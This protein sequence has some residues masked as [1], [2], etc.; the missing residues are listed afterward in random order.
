MRVPAECFYVRFGSFANFLWLQDTLAKWGGDAQ[1]LI[2]LR[3]LDR[4]MSGRMEKQLVLKQTV[5]S[6]M[7]GD[8]VIADV[9]IIGTDMFFREGASYG[10]LF[11][12]RNNLGLSA[13][14]DPAAAGADQGRRREGGESQDRRP[15]RFRTWRRPTE[16]SARTTWS[17]AI[18]ISS[19]RRRSWSSGSWPRRRARGRLGASK[20]FRHARTRHADQPQRHDLALRFRRLLPQHHRPALPRRDGAAVAGGGRHRTGATGQAGGGQRRQAGRHDRATQGGQPA[21]RPSSGRCPT[22]AAS[23]SK[24]ARSYDSLRGRRGAFLPV[25]DMPVDKV[26]RA[27]VSEYNKFAEFYRANWG[28]MD[29]IIAGVKRTALKDNREQVV[30]DVLMSPFAPQHFDAAEAM[31]WPGRRAAVGADRRRHGGGGGGADRSADLRRA[32]RRGA[33]AERRRDAVGCRW[34]GSATC[35]SATSAR[36]ANL[37]LLSVLNIG[38]PPRSDAAGYAGSP[39]GGW[40]R[41]FE[42][43][44]RLLVPARGARSGRAAASFREGRSGRP[45]CGCASA[46]S[47]NARITP[48]LNDLGYARTRETSL[49]NLRLLHALDQQLHVPPAACRE[50]AEF[51]LDAKLICPLGG[52]VRLARE[53][54][55]SRRIGPRPR[56]SRPSRAAS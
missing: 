55:T 24:A 37:G 38:I 44:H 11:H 32:A 20:E 27:E 47:R 17:T 28:R 48:A 6:R 9:A 51:L 30:V 36:P 14:L 31:A 50:A 4:G 52:Q 25:P 8:T 22:A 35:W 43:L 5:L 54:P 46:T 40:R 21:C 2:A 1:N 13:S 42:P 29:P 39:L 33:A 16:R 19:P 3:G 53:R 26:T 18:S 56:W 7:L 41:Q 15:R 12:A 45:R 10:I 23:C 34:E 49:G